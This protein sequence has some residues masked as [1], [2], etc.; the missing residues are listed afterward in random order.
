MENIGQLLS[1]VGLDFSDVVK[2]TIFLANMSDF[3]EVNKV[4]AKR[5]SSDP[6]ARSTVEVSALPRSVLI[7]IEVVA[8]CRS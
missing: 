1:S 2:T 5:F 4:Y 7:E 3:A 6:P 8:L